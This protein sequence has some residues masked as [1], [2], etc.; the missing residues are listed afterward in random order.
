MS[1]WLSHSP[2]T[3]MN[4]DGRRV[5]SRIRSGLA[6]SGRHQSAGEAMRKWLVMLAGVLQGYLE[7][8][9]GG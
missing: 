9:L 2:P 1:L 5:V 7:D 8:L 6:G 4:R 3:R